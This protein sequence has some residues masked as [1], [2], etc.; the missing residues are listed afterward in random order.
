MSAARGFT[1]DWG[2]GVGRDAADARGARSRTPVTLGKRVREETPEVA[3]VDD[4]TA[5][6]G[7]SFYHGFLDCQYKTVSCAECVD[8]ATKLFQPLAFISRAQTASIELLNGGMSLNLPA[9]QDLVAK[10]QRHG[11]EA[12]L[13]E[14]AQHL[15]DVRRVLSHAAVD[16]FF[17]GDP[18]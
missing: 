11:L 16:E 12:A 2:A 4:Q 7:L 13:T 14:V 8:V 15:H 1:F 17:S 9:I 5:E 10:V 3:G 6:D 18:E